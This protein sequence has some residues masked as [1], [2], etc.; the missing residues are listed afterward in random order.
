MAN[1][2]FTIGSA[3][4]LVT[5]LGLLTDP[6]MVLMPSAAQ[7]TVL[8]LAALVAAL[9][10]AFVMYER[11]GDERDMLHRMHAGRI[12]YLSGIAVLIV[13]L[14]VQGFA[15]AIDPWVSLALATMVISKLAARWY[16]EL[17]N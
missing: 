2:I 11:P 15:H 9:F 7:M 3:V 10:A 5:L 1:N 16:L 17:T 14:L 13:A 6:F 4:A 12:A 8:L